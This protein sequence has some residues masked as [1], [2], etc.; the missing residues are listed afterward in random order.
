MSKIIDYNHS[1]NKD[2]GTEQG[3]GAWAFGAVN[4]DTYSMIM[5]YINSTNNFDWKTLSS[6]PKTD[7]Q[8]VVNNPNKYWDWGTISCRKDLD[9]ELVKKYPYKPW[10]WEVLSEKFP[11]EEVSKIYNLIYSGLK[12]KL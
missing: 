1:A 4:F 12:N 10:N 6:D 9:L 11:H 5:N 8:V 2:E 3:S 7:L